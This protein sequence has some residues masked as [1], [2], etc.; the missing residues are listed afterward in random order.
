VVLP[1]AVYPEAEAKKALVM[2]L[3]VRKRWLKEA[4]QCPVLVLRCLLSF[5]AEAQ[6]R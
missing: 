1:E 3:K 4:Y 5:P 2:R 6:A